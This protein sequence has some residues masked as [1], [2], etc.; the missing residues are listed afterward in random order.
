MGC[1]LSSCWEVEN[2][3]GQLELEILPQQLSAKYELGNKIG[4]GS[5]ST[6]FSLKKK[7]NQPV[8]SEATFAKTVLACKVIH[9]KKLIKLGSQ[10]GCE[11]DILNQ[12][13]KEIDVL[14]N[15]SHPHIVSY[16]DYLETRTRIFIV[17]EKIIGQELFNHI[18]DFGPVSEKVCQHVIQCIMSALIYLHDRG[19]IHRDIKA[20][21]VIYY[22]KK[23]GTK[24]VV[25]LID[26]GFSTILKHDLT[27]S[28]L[29]TSGYIAPEIRQNHHYNSSVDNWACGV[30]MYMM[31]SAQLPFEPGIN[32]FKRKSCQCNRLLLD[33]CSHRRTSAE[34]RR[35]PR[36][37]QNSLPSQQMGIGINSV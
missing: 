24:P 13:R 37:I 11:N 18:L 7:P 26:F 28:F 6:V 27:G 31:L 20:E 25:K 36:A 12:L 35:M 1:F 5:T 22:E 33:Y 8:R 14:K 2:G 9:K 19:I 21:N 30:L 34:E 17:T 3:G 10:T 4:E 32:V 29:G 15:I 16:V 23:D